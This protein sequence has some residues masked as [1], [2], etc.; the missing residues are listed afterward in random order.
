VQLWLLVLLALGS[1][2]CEA[3][4]GIFKAG[5]WVGIVFAI[6][7]IVAIFAIARLFR[8]T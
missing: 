5:M 3:V 4:A 6:I 8:R 1:S 2:G 7:V